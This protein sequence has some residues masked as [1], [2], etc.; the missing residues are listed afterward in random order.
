M[1]TSLKALRRS[2]ALETRAKQFFTGLP[3][4]NG[5]LSPRW[6]TSGQCVACGR[7]SA[8]RGRERIRKMMAGEA[9]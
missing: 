5:H 3:C 8:A 7:E 6:T 4:L 9:T 1:K 2:E